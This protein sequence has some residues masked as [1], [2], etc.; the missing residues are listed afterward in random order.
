MEAEAIS[1]AINFIEAL[2]DEISWVVVK[3]TEE[4]TQTIGREF[5]LSRL[6]AAKEGI[7]NV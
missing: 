5:V 1:A 4:E 3:K 6:K 7:K 2:P